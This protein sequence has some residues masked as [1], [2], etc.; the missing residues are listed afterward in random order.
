MKHVTLALAL[1]AGLA[2]PGCGAAQQSSTEP[3][4]ASDRADSEPAEQ[5]AA[6]A[7]AEGDSTEPPVPVET[8]V[9][10][11]SPPRTEVESLQ[12]DEEGAG[13]RD[14]PADGVRVL[15]HVD[16]RNCSRFR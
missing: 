1:F 16:R 11:S 7:V 13:E 12:Q 9:E 2:A 6:E 14:E 15:R 10:P 8:I 3:S 5:T 4:T